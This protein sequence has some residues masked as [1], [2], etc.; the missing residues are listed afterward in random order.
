MKQW[1][2]LCVLACVSNAF[3]RDALKEPSWETLAL[4]TPESVLV[5][6][7]D[8]RKVLLVS[9]IEGGHSDADAKGGVALLAADGKIINQDF[10]RGLN[11]PKGMAVFAGTLYVADMTELVAIDLADRS[12]VQ[13]YPVE[14]ASFLND[15]AVDGDGVVYVS[16]THTGK[17]HRLI[18]GKLDTYR[19]GLAGA[20]GLYTLADAL[21]IGAGKRLYRTTSAGDMTLVAEGFAEDVDGVEALNDG[22]FIVSC[23]AGLIYHLQEDGT[24]QLLLDSR[25]EQINTA[26]IGYDPATDTLFVPT[27]LKHSVRA[28]SL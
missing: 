11:A 16:D 10:V 9:E 8:G 22:G 12:V 14:G 2:G 25:K 21:Y 7:I 24:L 5:H 23:W 6:Q 19:E 26:D 28:Y 4:R 18:N 27:F 15:V 3:A 20:N 17:V 13:R 1:V